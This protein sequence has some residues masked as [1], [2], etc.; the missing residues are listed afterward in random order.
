MGVLFR[1]LDTSP[2]PSEESPAPT[3]RESAGVAVVFG[4]TGDPFGAAFLSQLADLCAQ[5]GWRLIQ[6]DCGG[7]PDVQEGQVVDFLSNETADV[8][9]LYAVGEQEAAAAQVKA[10]RERC[11]VITVG[12]RVAPS[13]RRYVDVHVGGAENGAASALGGYLNESRLKGGEVL[14]LMDLPDEESGARK[15]AFSAEGVAVLDENYT[16]G[17]KI[18]AE[19]YLETGLDRFHEAD[20]IVC[21]SRHGTR[22]SLNT[23]RQ[24]ELRE[25]IKILSLTYDPSLDDDLALGDLD[26][27]AALSPKEAAEATV[28]LLPKVAKG[29]KVEETVLEYHVLTPENINETDLGY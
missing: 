22:G 20:A 7:K 27:A 15:R 5:Q 25:K 1:V 17:D 11:G 14:L 4:T 28:G 6:Y 9:V 2:P 29:E 26:A 18:Y 8:A 10:L 19:R 21:A 3:P 13:A 12:R 23:L 16:W 24:R